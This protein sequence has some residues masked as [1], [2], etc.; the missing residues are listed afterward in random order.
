M[1]FKQRAVRERKIERTWNRLLK[2]LHFVESIGQEQEPLM[3][4]EVEIRSSCAG[5]NFKDVL[6]TL[7]SLNDRNIG[8]EVAGTVV[9]L[10]SSALE[11]SNLNV[12]DR[13][14]CFA[15]GS[16][17]TFTRCHFRSIAKI[18][19]GIDFPSAAAIPVNFVTAW[20]AFHGIARLR[21]GETVLVHS[22][23]GGTG[24]AAVQVAQHIGAVV[25]A[26]VGSESKRSFL[27]ER[28]GVPTD[29]IFSSRDTS[30]LSGVRRMTQNKGVDVVL[31]SLSGDG[32]MASWEFIAPYGRFVEIGKKDIFA[33]GS[34]SMNVFEKNVSFAAVDVSMLNRDR[35]GVV[36][37]ALKSI[38]ALAANGSLC[39]AYPLHIYRVSEIQQA[40]RSLQSGNTTGKVVIQLRADD[41]VQTVLGPKSSCSM[42][43]NATYVIAGGLGG[44]GQ[45]VARWLVNQGAR[46]LILLSR[47]GGQSETSRS[48]VRRL[49]DQGAHV[50]TP[51]CDITDLKSLRTAIDQ[52]M[53]TMP[54]IRGCIQAA[55]VLQ[56]HLLIFG[57]FN[58]HAT[59]PKGMD[60]FIMLSAMAGVCGSRGEANYA[61]G[62]TYQ[63][64]LARYR[65]DRGERATALDLGPFHEMGWNSTAAKAVKEALAY[66]VAET[67]GLGCEEMDTEVPMHRSGVD[68][69]IAVELCNWVTRKVCADVATLDFMGSATVA[70]I[71]RTAASKSKFRKEGWMD[72]SDL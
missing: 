7:G 30:F 53:L 68:S 62:N 41:T 11:E 25:Y 31:N 65:L 59:L 39:P 71:A 60:F 29:R 49:T 42:D 72:S 61:A 36:G 18:P 4:E 45:S 1:R 20:Y 5:V 10:G 70:K 52:C 27:S 8:C 67:L 23:A 28:Y 3:P 32:L 17:A 21:P 24:Q 55:M 63:D 34:L 16:F 47:P 33:H 50:E 13:V 2:T 22:A 58:L 15:T 57:S 37:K 6:V 26:T 19:D 12:G 44:L 46:N 38:F 64:S 54:P 51:A 56:T 66:K 43:P 48:L 35:P 14:A 69:L 9:R 40:F